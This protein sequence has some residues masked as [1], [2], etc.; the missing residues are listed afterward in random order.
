MTYIVDAETLEAAE[1]QYHD[2]LEID[3]ILEEV[4]GCDLVEADPIDI[5]EELKLIAA[6]G[7]KVHVQHWNAENGGSDWRAH[8]KLQIEDFGTTVLDIEPEY[9]LVADLDQNGRAHT[10][11]SFKLEHIN[12]IGFEVSLGT[13]IYLEG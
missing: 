8:G 1:K 4:I 7:D 13:I 2:G 12:R 6:T 9:E 11:A 10:Y 3:S 5:V